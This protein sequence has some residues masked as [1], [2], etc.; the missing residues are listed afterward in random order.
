MDVKCKNWKVFKVI[1]NKVEIWVSLKYH[2]WTSF[3]NS[4]VFN[5]CW[6]GPFS[7]IWQKFVWVC[8]CSFIGL[9]IWNFFKVFQRWVEIFFGTFWLFCV[10]YIVSL[11]VRLYR[12][13]WGQR[14]GRIQRTYAVFVRVILHIYF[15]VISTW[16]FYLL[17]TNLLHWFFNNY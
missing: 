2:K 5:Y 7:F 6:N 8:C 13:I 3:L 4:K 11:I 14:R 1:F 12:I 16:H 10:P 17:L 9:N 15:C